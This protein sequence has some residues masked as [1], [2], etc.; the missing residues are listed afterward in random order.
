MGTGCHRRPSLGSLR[1]GAHPRWRGLLPTYQLFITCNSMLGPRS[2]GCIRAISKGGCCQAS[3]GAPKRRR[4]LPRIA[5][6][7]PPGKGPGGCLEGWRLCTPNLGRAASISWDGCRCVS[8]S[9]D[10]FSQVGSSC[11]GGRAPRGRVP[12][13][14]A[15]GE[16][17]GQREEGESPRRARAPRGRGWGLP[18][19][20]RCAAAGR[21]EGRPSGRAGRSGGSG[22]PRLPQREGGG[23]GKGARQTTRT[24]NNR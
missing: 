4:G 17:G 13:R 1:T 23:G 3:G 2:S 12:W 16:G 15:R 18:E 11:T 7:T 24:Q 19:G 10:S 8:E 6:G 22:E 14:V 9:S 5:K 20:A 21:V